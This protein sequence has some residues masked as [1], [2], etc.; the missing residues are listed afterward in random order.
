VGNTLDTLL[1]F[2]FYVER[3]GIRNPWELEGTKLNTRCSGDD[4]IAT[5]HTSM[6]RD[7]SN[8]ILNNSSRVKTGPAIGLG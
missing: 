6:S 8:T 1:M 7:I 5:A 2:Y 4:L 3:S